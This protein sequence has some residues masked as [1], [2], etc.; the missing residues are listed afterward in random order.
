MG[1]AAILRWHRRNVHRYATTGANPRHAPAVRE[2][3]QPPRQR[4]SRRL[5]VRSWTNTPKTL[6]GSRNDSIL[7]AVCPI[8]V[9]PCG[10]TTGQFGGAKTYVSEETYRLR[11]IQTA[12]SVLHGIVV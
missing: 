5:V 12:R 11:I 9:T 1:T 8:D 2:S 10:G 4:L 7:G 3:R 6:F